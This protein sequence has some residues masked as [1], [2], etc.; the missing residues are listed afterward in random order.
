M[1]VLDWTQGRRWCD[2]APATT[3]SGDAGEAG[4]G[5]QG[6]GSGGSR[7]DLAK[8]GS[9]ANSLGGDSGHLREREHLE[10]ERRR[11][12]ENEG[13]ERNEA[14]PGGFGGGG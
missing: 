9:M 7:S 3:G 8:A 6:P 13:W 1:F 12:K 2:E 14:G 5:S 4:N 11:E 10:R